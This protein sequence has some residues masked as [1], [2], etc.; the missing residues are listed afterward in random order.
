MIPRSTTVDWIEIDDWFVVVGIWDG[1][2][3]SLI[4]DVMDG[5]L[6]LLVEV[7]RTQ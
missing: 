7:I 4:V 2:V 6:L 3:M 5:W 1:R